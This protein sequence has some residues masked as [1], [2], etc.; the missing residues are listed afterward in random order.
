MT[1][2]TSPGRAAS[3]L[4][5]TAIGACAWSSPRSSSPSRGNARW[6]QHGVAP[7][8]SRGVSASAC[9]RSTAPIESPSASNSQSDPRPAPRPIAPAAERST[10]AKRPFIAAATPVR[11]S[12]AA[13]GRNGSPCRGRAGSRR[14]SGPVRMPRAT[15]SAGMTAAMPGSR[16]SARPVSSRIAISAASGAWR[17]A[18]IIAATPEHRV[19]DRRGAQAGR[20]RVTDDSHAAPAVAPITTIGPISPPGRRGRRRRSSPASAAR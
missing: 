2:Q 4:Q 20:Q 6:R 1:P 10:I 3:P 12:S 17:L 13:T 9:A 8:A 18:P 5:T 7:T 11:S 15:S 16:T 14:R 19:Q